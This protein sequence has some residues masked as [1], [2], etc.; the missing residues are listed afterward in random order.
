[1]TVIG[2][3]RDSPPFCKKMCLFDAFGDIF[4]GDLGICVAVLMVF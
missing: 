3:W 2:F 4:G 1:V